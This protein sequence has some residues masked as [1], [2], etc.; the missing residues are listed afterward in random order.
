MQ[1]FASGFAEPIGGLYFGANGGSGFALRVANGVRSGFAELAPDELRMYQLIELEANAAA[2]NITTPY[3]PAIQSSS[4]EAA[5]ALE[6]VQNGA[7]VYK[8]GVLGR[9]ETAGSQ[10][11]SLENPLN[12]GYVGRYGIPPQNANFN[13]ILSGTVE[14]GA[15]VITRIAPGIPP[16]P[17]GGI[18][19]VTNPGSFRLDSFY[20]P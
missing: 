1:G 6:Q 13:F 15:P 3:G 18:E 7:T 10:F 5:A 20:M 17:G 12:P 14:P 8:G 16:N 19:A 4:P 2:E 11:L 9:S